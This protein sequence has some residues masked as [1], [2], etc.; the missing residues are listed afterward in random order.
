MAKLEKQPTVTV[1]SPEDKLN[2]KE[3]I[4]RAEAE[5]LSRAEKIKNL[6]N[7]IESMYDYDHEEIDVL[8]R[9]LEPGVN[10]FNF[11]F[12]GPYKSDDFVE[13]CLYS[14]QRYR[15]QRQVVRHLNKNCFYVEYQPLS[16]KP[17]DITGVQAAYNN[18]RVNSPDSM[19]IKKEVHR[20]EAIPLSFSQQDPD[21]FPSSVVQVTY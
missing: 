4:N 3:A 20:C 6:H 16:Q 21:L 18:G 11:R 17:N 13:Y 2:I 7:K 15:L 5:R 12:K 8:F 1:N 19:R 14:G 9:I 10:T